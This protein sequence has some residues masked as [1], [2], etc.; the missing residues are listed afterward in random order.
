MNPIQELYIYNLYPL[1][2]EDLIKVITFMKRINANDFGI[3]YFGT[4]L[5]SRKFALE[6][7]NSVWSYL[8]T[9]RKFRDITEVNYSSTICNQTINMIESIS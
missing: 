4:V 7:L 6:M 5:Y 1:E 2:R 3:H 9:L 8:S